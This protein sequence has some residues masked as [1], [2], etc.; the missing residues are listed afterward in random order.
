MAE[1]GPED[2]AKFYRDILRQFAILKR[3]IP[4]HVVP[5]SYQEF[6]CDPEVYLRKI[7]TSI[8]ATFSAAALADPHFE[9]GNVSDPLLYQPVKNYGQD[10]REYLSEDEA[11]IVDQMTA[12][13]REFMAEW[14]SQLHVDG[15]GDA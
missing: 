8:D 4:N 7:F 2:F 6:V 14:F 12:P 10:W 11:S 15:N 3:K 9:E 1:P 5:F 13:D